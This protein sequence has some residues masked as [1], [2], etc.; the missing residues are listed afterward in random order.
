MDNC[1]NCNCNTEMDEVQKE[2]VQKILKGSG[3][4]ISEED[5]YAKRRQDSID[6]CA[7]EM[8]VTRL[9]KRIRN[10]KRELKRLNRLVA[11]LKHVPRLS[12]HTMKLP[13]VV[14]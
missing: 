7:M 14:E 3:F 10:Q 11:A 4:W 9:R 8:E 6:L 2:A 5:Y 1:N 12:D 13:C